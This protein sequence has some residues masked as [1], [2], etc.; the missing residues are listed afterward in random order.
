MLHQRIVSP[1][2]FGMCFGHGKLSY[3]GHEQLFPVSPSPNNIPPAVSK[4]EET[5]ERKKGNS[6]AR[7]AVDLEETQERKQHRAKRGGLRG[8]TREETSSREAGGYANKQ[9]WIPTIYGITGLKYCTQTRVN[10]T[11]SALKLKITI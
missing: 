3:L 10:T 4:L 2:V 8:N 9:R 1:K 5:E 7:S 6:T 11:H